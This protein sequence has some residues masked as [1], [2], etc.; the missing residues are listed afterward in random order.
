MNYL[1]RQYWP[2]TMCV[3]GAF[4]GSDTSQHGPARP[5][6]EANGEMAGPALTG[7]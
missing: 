1:L 2:T 6:I 7:I 3:H 4:I 5:S